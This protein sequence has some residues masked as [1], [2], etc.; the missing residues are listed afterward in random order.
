MTKLLP[1]VLAVVV[2]S[3]LLSG[4]NGGNSMPPPGAGS[5][6]NPSAAMPP[7]ARAQNLV[8]VSDQLEK[9][10]LAF[11]A[12]ERAQNP[13]PAQTLNLGVIPEGIW[14]DN[15]G[16]LYAAVS[17]SS[18]KEAGKVEEFKPGSSTPFLTITN[19]IGSPSFVVVDQ[20]GTLYVDQTFDLSVQ[21]LEYPAGKTSPS[22]TL[23]ITEKGEG[24]AGPM[25]LDAHGNLYVHTSFI[26]NPPSKVYRFAPGNSIPHN[27]QLKGLGATTGLASDKFGN[28]Y[29][30]DAKGGISVYPPGRKN[31]LREITPPQNDTFDDFVATRS[32]KLYVAEGAGSSVASL[33]EYAV[34]GS[35]PVNVL[36]GHL[37]APLMPAL[38]AAAF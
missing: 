31:P 21:I 17:G 7:P 34:G 38:R 36:T 27:L 14:V 6:V 33:L 24:A 4:C 13:P 23:S 19:G 15:A 29:V 8:Y 25:M 37:E 16:I 10:I 22:T 12:S 1:E 5:A 11:P 18:S 32:G 30:S 2:F 9:A 3:A 35:Q 28:L 20:N 26:D